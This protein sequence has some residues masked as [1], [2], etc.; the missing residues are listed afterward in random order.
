MLGID[1][2]A[3]RYTWTAAL[4]VLLLCLFYLIRTTL[5]VFVLALLFAYLLSPLVNVIDRFLPGKGT[6]TLALTIAYVLFIAA[7]FAA[8]TQIGSRVIEQAN[9]LAKSMPALLQKLQQP[10]PGNSL[11]A[12]LIARIQ[13]QVARSSSDVF[14]LLPRAGSRIIALASNL[15][16]VV[17]IPILGFFFLK[18]GGE[19]RR[20]F[21]ELIDDESQRVRVDDLLADIDLLL[22]R[23]M[24]AILLL[25]VATFTA[26]SIFFSILHVPFS[27]LLAAL[28]GSLEFIPMIGPV[29]AGALILIVTL[30]NGGPFVGAL[31][32]LCVYRV[33][34]DYILAPQ[35]MRTGM[36]L[37]PL[38]ILFGVF[39]GA[40][41][42]GVP[43]AFL[44]VPVLALIR[45]VYR[46]LRSRRI[47]MVIPEVP[48]AET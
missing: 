25:S 20:H 34:Q 27:I 24:R 1:T 45:I 37:H 43:G 12:E 19:I 7:L 29:T 22:A 26:Y 21:L 18:D 11:R 6:R 32:F 13:E 38:L 42:S 10:V 8:V 5:F 15:I 14:A 33:F 4:T 17:I 48:A 46:R 44:S 16:Y 9:T 28:A 47:A 40:E 2:R 35:L 23:Y 30:V 41:L 31:V 39:A 3:A 36:K